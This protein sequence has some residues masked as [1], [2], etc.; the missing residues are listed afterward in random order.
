MDCVM[1][2]QSEYSMINS[3]HISLPC[4]DRHHWHCTDCYRLVFIQAVQT[5]RCASIQAVQTQR[6]ASIQAVQTQRCASTQAVQTQRC[7]SIQAVQTQRCASI[8][9]AQ[10][11]RCAS[12]QA[13]QTQRCASIQAVQ[14]QRCASIQAVQTQ[15]CV[16]NPA[17]YLAHFSFYAR[18]QNC[19]KRLSASSC[20]SVRP[21][22]TTRLQ[23]GGGD[24][25]E[26][27]RWSIFRKTVEKIQ[28][29]LKSDNN[30]GTAHA[31]RHTVLVS[32]LSLSQFFL[33][34]EK[35]GTKVVGEIKKHILCL[36]IFFFRKSCL[37]W[38]YV[39]KYCRAGSPQMT[40][41]RMRIAYWI[42]K[43]ANTYSEYVT[44]IAFPL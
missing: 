4:S 2:S 5:Q 21:H 38:D 17:S 26:I 35:F 19:E 12:I 11:Q 9:A 15:R 1:T 42:P 33:E 34:W 18:S 20:L 43:A 10:T 40:V 24:F 22:G 29:V 3:E 6:C 28:A 25:H 30:N 7:A 36:I 8:Q 27:W 16:S 39:G 31:D 44:L 13:M 32:S 41:W 14:T 37:L 23:L